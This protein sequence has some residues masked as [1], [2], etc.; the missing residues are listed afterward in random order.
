[1]Y[2]PKIT[3]ALLTLAL[4]TGPYLLNAQE[5]KVRVTVKADLVGKADEDHGVVNVVKGDAGSVVA[6]MTKGGDPVMG[7]L[8]QVQTDWS[9]WSYATGTMLPIKNDKPK[10]VWGEGPVALETIVHFAGQFRLIASKP[11]PE[12]GKLLIIQQVLSPRALTGKGAQLVT[13]LPYDRLGK[14]AD[15]YQSNMTIGFTTLVN[16]DS[17]KLLLQLTPNSTTRSAGCPVF[18]MMLGKDLKPLWNYTL[19][20]DLAAKEVKLLDTQVDKNGAV[21]YLVKNISDPAPK[22]KGVIGYTHAVYK[23]DSAGQ[24]MVPIDMPAGNYAMDA[25]MAFRADGNLSVAG[26]YSNVENNRNEAVGLYAST[27]N[28]TTMVLGPWKQYPLAKQLVE[29]KMKKEERLQTNIVLNRVLPKKDGGTF[30]VA[31]GSALITTMVSDLS[32]AKKPKYSWDNWDLHIMELTP[33]GDLRWYKQI[34]RDM[35][36]ENDL[37]GRLISATF[38]DQLF[39]LLND[40]EAGY[41]KRRNKEPLEQLTSAKDATLFEFK[42]D[43]TEKPRRILSEGGG[44]GCFIPSSEWRLSPSTIVTLGASGFGAKSTFPVMIQFSKEAQK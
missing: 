20:T 40:D 8:S 10:V 35:S 12:N 41:E 19:Q 3:T 17:T 32:G 33:S 15:Y 24:R 18:A 30:L 6:L 14:G 11:D 43:G 29:V 39:V 34:E 42:P 38:D 28:V 13:E 21:W 16:A 7:G 9:L 44:Q 5:S 4:C 27:L 2:T 23:L 26:V 22:T 37:P 25:S 31:H 1:M 36:F